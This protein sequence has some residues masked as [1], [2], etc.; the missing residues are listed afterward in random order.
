MD[1]NNS[2]VIVGRREWAEV[3]ESIGRINDNEKITIT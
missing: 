3:E 1:T 2:L